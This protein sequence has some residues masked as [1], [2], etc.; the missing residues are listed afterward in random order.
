MSVQK[1]LSTWRRRWLS[2]ALV[3][4]IVHGLVAM[5]TI[6]SPKE[7]GATS[8]LYVSTQGASSTSDLVSGSTFAQSQVQSY[9]DVAKAPV[10]LEPVIRQLDLQ[11]SPA[12]LSRRVTVT[13]PE[14]TVLL[15]IE[16]RDNDPVRAAEVGN[17]ISAHFMKRVSSLE[18]TGTSSKTPIK[19]SVLRPAAPRATPVSP[20]PVRNL[21][22]GV[23]L[24]VLLGLGVALVRE[25]L[26]TSLHR[27]EDV[28]GLTDLPILGSIPLDTRTHRRPLS[29]DG[30]SSSIR[31]EA[32]RA[33]RTNLQFVRAGDRLRSLVLTS[34][35]PGE[36]KTTTVANLAHVLAAAGNRVCV[37]EGDLRRPSLLDYLGLEGSAGLTNVLIGQITLAE[38][39][40][41][42][43][44]NLMVLG[45]GPIPPNPSELLG[46]A[47]M[48]RL[49]TVLED[50]FDIVLIDSPPVLPVTDAVVL[51]RIVSG[52]V[53][54]VGIEVVDRDSLTRTL[55]SLEA[56]DSN[57]AGLILNRSK[58]ES[59]AQSEYSYEY[60]ARDYSR[61]L[62]ATPTKESSS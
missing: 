28:E 50:Q 24:A 49:M 14:G 60:T 11:E 22:I 31:T 54:C 53:V 37:V 39:L 58:E 33:L 30:Q 41:D 6:F 1:I 21:I 4:L 5:V 55:K 19:V 35:L 48:E 23:A 7:Y 52:L 36:G 32:F 56:V 9:I 29:T 34:S 20:N 45:A 59:A 16:V 15:D 8:Q 27:K 44:E 42:G 18:S 40:Q 13:V 57:V 61:S 3:A 51:S 26:D 46:S 43:G 25:S 17:A 47:A 62:S 38:A 10:V 2:V 12:D